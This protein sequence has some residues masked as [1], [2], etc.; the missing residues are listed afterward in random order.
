MLMTINPKTNQW[1]KVLAIVKFALLI[2]SMAITV[3]NAAIAPF[4]FNSL[5][6]CIAIINVLLYTYMVSLLIF[7]AEKRA[8][9]IAFVVYL[10]LDI[11]AN[12]YGLVVVRFA[13]YQFSII[14]G[15]VIL[16]ATIYLFVVTM[17]VKNVYISFAFKFFAFSIFALSLLRILVTIIFPWIADSFSLAPHYP[18]LLRQI[19]NFLNLF[20][21]LMPVSVILMTRGANDYIQTEK[22]AWMDPHSE[23]E[24]TY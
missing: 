16:L 6:A 11:A 7:F 10:F 9:V 1:I 18:Y 2:G 15:I 5:T 8:I 17:L 3:A 22:A 13:G 24:E 20:W 23:T 12:V 4:I 14:L 19:I 21:L